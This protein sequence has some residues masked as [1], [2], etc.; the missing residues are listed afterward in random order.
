MH[1]R[2][3]KLEDAAA[4]ARVHIN[5]WQTT[6]SGLLPN[7]YI[8]KRSYEKRYNNWKKRLSVNRKA[9]TDYFIYVA[10]N[11]VK[12]IVGFVDGGLARGNSTCQGEIYALY[13][14]EAEQKKGIG[15]SLFKAIASRLSQS[16]LT[17]LMV[18]VLEGNPAIQF[19][20]ALDGRK[21]AQKLIK[22]NGIEFAEIAYGWNDTKV[23]MAK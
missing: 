18:W 23:L 12:E 10:E 16:G 9:E 4:I 5:S 1:I 8:E 2:E 6:Y 13:I 17:S 21:I 11:S 22:I 7:E 14:L 20:Q 19:Y 3:A 15:S